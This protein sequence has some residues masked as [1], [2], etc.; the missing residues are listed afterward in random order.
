MEKKYSLIN[1]NPF[2]NDGP[3]KLVCVISGTRISEIK[4]YKGS[5]KIK[6]KENNVAY[7]VMKP[8]KIQGSYAYGQTTAVKSVLVIDPMFPDGV[9]CDDIDKISDIYWCQAGLAKH[10]SWIDIQRK[11]ENKICVK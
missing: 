6:G 8:E 11:K 5:E 3:M 2:Y 7:T 9:Y 4:W 10:S 1:K